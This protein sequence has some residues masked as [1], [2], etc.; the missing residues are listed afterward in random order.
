MSQ[1]FIAVMPPEGYAERVKQFQ[2]N[3][4]I[5]QI[6][7]HITV[8]AQGGLTPDEKWIAK[9]EEI[10]S[11]FPTFELALGEPNMFSEAVLY[12]TVQSE[13]VKRLHKEIVRAI[14][15]SEELVQQYFELDSY[16]PHM[17]IAQTKNGL[18]VNQLV[19]LKGKAE[20]Q[21]S[22]FPIFEVQLIRIYKKV[23]PDEGYI[24]LKD[25]EFSHK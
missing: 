19:D 1:Y 5:Q 24:K 22:P 10:C 11:Q 8:K 23:N 13:E 14:H 16:I 2:S 3:Q 20:Q 15:P 9:I 18:L 17:T 6:E 12:L 21:L 4:G 25:I 7:P